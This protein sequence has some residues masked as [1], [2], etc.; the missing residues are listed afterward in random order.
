V[1]GCQAWLAANDLKEPAPVDQATASY[2]EE[3]DVIGRFLTECCLLNPQVRVQGSV[4]Y[5]AYKHWCDESNEHA[6]TSTAF[7]TRLEKDGFAK[8]K[9]SAMWRWGIALKT[10]DAD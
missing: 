9:S 3:M 6:V 7:G 5:N 1:R 8:Q 4:L 2:R 10:E